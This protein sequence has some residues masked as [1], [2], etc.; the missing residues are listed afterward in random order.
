FIVEG[1]PAVL[2]GI[3]TVFY[4]TDRPSHAAWLDP[5]EQKWLANE[6]HAELEAKKRLRNYTIKEAFSD[7]HILTLITAYFLALTGSLGTIYWIPT[8]LKRISGFSNQTV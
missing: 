1:I 3:L 2:V 4:M 6:L 8:F 5:E 7:R